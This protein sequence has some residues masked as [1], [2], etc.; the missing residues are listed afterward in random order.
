MRNGIISL[1]SLL[2]LVASGLALDDIIT[3]IEVDYTA[4]YLVIGASVVWLIGAAIWVWI[5]RQESG[6]K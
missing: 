3:G 4:Q 5:D 1:V 2:A 6:G